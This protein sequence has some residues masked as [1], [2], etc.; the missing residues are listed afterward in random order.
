M[1]KSPKHNFNVMTLPFIINNYYNKTS[2]Y[3]YKT[4]LIA[5]KTSIDKQDDDDEFLKQIFWWLFW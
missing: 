1:Y 3:I 5:I 2:I 4:M